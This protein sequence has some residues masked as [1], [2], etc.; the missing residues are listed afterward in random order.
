[1]AAG[2]TCRQH[3]TNDG[4]ALIFENTDKNNKTVTVDLTGSENIMIEDGDFLKWSEEVNLKPGQT[5]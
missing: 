3:L 4:G 2:L 1:M 5:K